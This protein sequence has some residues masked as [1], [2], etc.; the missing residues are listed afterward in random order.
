MEGKVVFQIIE[1]EGLELE[2]LM[3]K[4]SSIL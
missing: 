1:I 3:G 4:F 2:L